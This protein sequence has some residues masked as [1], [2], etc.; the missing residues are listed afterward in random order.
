MYFLYYSSVS[1]MTP[2]IFALAFGLTTSPL[3]VNGVALDS[4]GFLVK[5]VM[6]VL[7]RA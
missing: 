4:L 5:W 6:V 7:R 1:M 3:V 2:R